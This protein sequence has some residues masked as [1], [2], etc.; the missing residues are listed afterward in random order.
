MLTRSNYRPFFRN[1]SY[2]LNG[3]IVHVGSGNVPA[4]RP[5]QKVMVDLT[6]DHDLNPSTEYNIRVRLEPRGQKPILLS[7][8][9]RVGE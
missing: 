5:F 2:V 6:C 9:I 8:Q 4:L 3:Q 1:L 7:G